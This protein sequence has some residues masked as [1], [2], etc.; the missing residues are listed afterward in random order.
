VIWEDGEELPVGFTKK[1]IGFPR[2]GNNCALCHTGTYRGSENDA[3]VVVTGAPAHA[4]NMQG[5]FAFLFK[6][7]A[8][9]RFNG[10]TITSEIDQL[11]K[12]S[13]VDRLLYRHLIIPVVRKRI[14]EQAKLGAWML[15]PQR[16][17]WGPGRDDAFNLPKYFV[18]G[19]PVDDSTGQCDFNSVWNMG[20]RSAPGR[21]MN[22]AGETPALRSIVI[23]SALG[24][25]VRPGLTFEKRVAEL[26]QFMSDLRAPKFPFPIDS[27][28]AAA[29]EQIYSARCAECH[30]VG[31]ARTNRVVPIDE[32]G[33]DRAR[34]DT[35]TQNAADRFN[36]V[37]KEKGF[38][39]PGVVKSDGYLS[40]PLD[41]IWMRAPYLHNGSVPTLRDLLNVAAE[42]PAAFHRGYDVFDPAKVGWREPDAQSVTSASQQNPP[43]FLF[44]IRRRGDGNSGH[45]YGTDLTPEEK[46]SLVE[47]MKTL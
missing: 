8:D 32:I 14:L 10:D 37:M 28:R 18:A 38:E 25:G 39:R 30:A 13:A 20:V 41:G 24:V 4:L 23:D 36:T 27:A 1:V 7:A 31:A 3:P 2:V 42:R 11:T 43:L 33:T 17:A 29:G 46:E 26:E 5:M 34:F 9:P 21:V 44:D 19:M 15:D 45:L 35:W 22:W 40:P 6:A 12:L 16:P 47:Y